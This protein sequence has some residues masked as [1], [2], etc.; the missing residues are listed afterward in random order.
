MKQP[1]TGALGPDKGIEENIAHAGTSHGGWWRQ[2]WNSLPP[3]DE[4]PLLKYVIYRLE[5]SANLSL[6]AA[7]RQFLLCT[8]GVLIF[9]AA[10]SLSLPVLTTI[11]PASEIHWIHS[12]NHTLLE[13]LGGLIAIIIGIILS[14]EYSTSGKRNVLF[15]VYAFFSIGILDFFHAF[16]DYCHNLFVWFHS[17]GALLGSIFFFSSM[18]ASRYDEPYADES[19][20]IRRF[21][22]F[23]GVFLIL[24]FAVLSL[25][26]YS[27]IPEVLSVPLEHHTHVSL[28]KGEFSGFINAMNHVSGALYF[29]S[30]VL[31]LR[32][33]LKTN[34]VLYLIFGTSALLFFVSELFFAF[35]SLWNL[36]W[37]YWH[38]IKAFIF[39]G[40]LLGLAYG[41][42]KTFY[43]LYTSRMQLASLLANLEGKNVELEK[44]YV[45][46]KETQRYLSES[47]KLA[48]IGKMAAMMAHEIRNPLGAISNSIGVLK[49][50]RLRPEE[51]AELLGLVENEMERLNKLTEDFL[52]F[53]R[54]SHLR[55]SR[56]NL[57]D[58]LTETLSLL[59]SDKTESSRI[60]FQKSL[61][62]DIPLLML[63]RNHIKQVF[64]NI[65]MNSL[66][67]LSQGGVISV[68]TYYKRTEDEVE[69]TFSDTGTGMSEEVL[70]QVFQPFFTTK[71]K[72]LGLGLNIIHKIVKEHG[73][74]ILLSSKEG[75][76]TEVKLSFPVSDTVPP[77]AMDGAVSPHG[78]A[79]YD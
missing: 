37:W 8:I 47:E 12:G 54:P 22:I 75:E 18:F 38:I 58:L 30:G 39:S 25:T 4:E 72:G 49:N 6:S 66:Q 50:Y 53:A 61:A 10:I 26:F 60:V 48:S 28:V 35:S 14:W 67:A 13:S 52:S 63:D 29:A 5:D 44:A 65:L 20:W 1:D 34:D 3:K 55:R 74:Y 23:S 40:M 36:M 21:S 41:F 51:N 78:A 15:L 62:P 32:G 9:V 59:S 7:R 2:L 27:H 77:R 79:A 31:F 42:T 45:T 46:L 70:S 11:Y 76:G 19:V 71:D 17:S 64:L 73:G 57:N 33:F 43:R 56:T 68:Q 69:V 16:S 24:I